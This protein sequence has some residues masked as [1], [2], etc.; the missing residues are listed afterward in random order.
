MIFLLSRGKSI[1]SLLEFIGHMLL[2]SGKTLIEKTLTAFD[3]GEKFTQSV[4]QVTM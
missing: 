2:I 1:S 4:A 3:F